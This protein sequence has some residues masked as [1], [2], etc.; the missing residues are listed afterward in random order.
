MPSILT[1]TFTHSS[2][3]WIQ[4]DL[5]MNDRHVQNL[6]W[7]LD[8]YET[9]L[10]LQNSCFT[11]GGIA[12]VFF[13][14]LTFRKFQKLVYY[15]SNKTRYKFCSLK[16]QR[17]VTATLTTLIHNKS[18]QRSSGVR[19]QC[20]R[21]APRMASPETFGSHHI[22]TLCIRFRMQALR[23]ARNNIMFH[24]IPMANSKQFP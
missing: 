20:N 8:T 19:L 14:F 18:T 5:K 1:D 7:S 17:Y 16:I 23:P 10:P 12:K 13:F 2:N 6:Q 3:V 21:L 15:G 11:H 9:S 24:T 4:S 22:T